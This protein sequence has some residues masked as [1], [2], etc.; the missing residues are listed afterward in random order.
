[1]SS[2]FDIHRISAQNDKND[3]SVLIKILI[4]QAI[5]SFQ[6]NKTTDSISHLHAAYDELVVFAKMNDRNIVNAR[7]LGSILVSILNSL[8]E[9]N[10][11]H[12]SAPA[13]IN[14]NSL[15]IADF[16]ALEDQVGRYL[17]HPLS[18]RNSTLNNTTNAAIPP[19][20][21]FI[22]HN[23]GYGASVQYPS[24]WSIRIENNSNLQQHKPYHFRS[25][26]IAS[27][28]MP[29]LSSGL[30][31][32][33]IGI[34]SNLSQRI[35][36]SPISLNDYLDLA[37]KSKNLTNFPN[38]KI[39]SSNLGDINNKNTLSGSPAYKLVWTY[40]NPIYGPRKVMEFGTIVGK[41]TGYFIDYSASIERFNEY[42][43]L[44]KKMKDTF[45]P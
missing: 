36:H 1:M 35:G 5:Q 26:V 10:N 42:L 30:P 37:V 7:A 20:T 29:R 16:N 13:T 18:I 17:L 31:T 14:N 4:D 28:Y 34:N 19:G 15:I 11:S 38:L 25:K 8:S 2:L 43:P 22:Y 24:N 21:F 44:V 40:I 45:V 9:E 6:N 23:D 3:N 33:Y 41:D 12:Y 39:I 32:F 27:F